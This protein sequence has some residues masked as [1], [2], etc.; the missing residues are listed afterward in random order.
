METRRLGGDHAAWRGGH[1]RQVLEA[2]AVGQ[3][4]QDDMRVVL[5]VRLREGSILDD[6]LRRRIRE[7]IRDGA[8]PH[9][10]PRKVLEVE[11]IPRTVNGKISEVAVQRVIHGQ[12]VN[13]RSALANPEALE[14]YRDRPELAED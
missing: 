1:L 14:H 9:H 7:A 6:D 12:S 3:L 4:R 5:F 11:D 2:V 13:N 8:S 10:V